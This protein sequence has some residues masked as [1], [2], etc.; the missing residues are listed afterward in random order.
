M[1]CR[2]DQRST[3]EGNLRTSDGTSRGRLHGATESSNGHTT[4][5]DRHHHRENG[6]SSENHSCHRS[7]GSHHPREPSNEPQDRAGI[8]H[9]PEEAH[10][11]RGLTGSGLVMT[12]YTQVNQVRQYYDGTPHSNTMTASSPGSDEPTIIYDAENS[13]RYR[14]SEPITDAELAAFREDFR[15][16]HARR[17]GDDGAARSNAQ[18][19]A[20]N[21]QGK[22]HRKYRCTNSLIGNQDPPQPGNLAQ[23]PRL[24]AKMTRSFA[25]DHVSQYELDSV[26]PNMQ[27]GRRC[28]CNSCLMNRKLH[29]QEETK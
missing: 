12:E 5:R 16:Q 17:N 6:E 20:S 1:S 29:R 11:T 19:V 28:S 21:P 9:F 8:L 26:F 13:D 23:I 4:H 27:D 18:S 22:S 7:H 2:S 14:R 3:A 24:E 10:H 15:S 25:W